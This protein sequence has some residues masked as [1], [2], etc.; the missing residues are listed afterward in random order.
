MKSNATKYLNK[1]DV[2][3]EQDDALKDHKQ[4]QK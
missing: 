4:D 1:N 2:Q 3:N